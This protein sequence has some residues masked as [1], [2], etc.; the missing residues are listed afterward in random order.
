MCKDIIC[1]CM[2]HVWM[3]LHGFTC[4]KQGLACL[5]QRNN[6]VGLAPATS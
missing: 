3:G 5:A 4:T 1:A 6:T 2:V